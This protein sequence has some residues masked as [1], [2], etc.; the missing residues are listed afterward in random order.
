MSSTVTEKVTLKNYFEGLS[1]I[2]LDY[3]YDNKD[4]I[5]ISDNKDKNIKKLIDNTKKGFILYILSAKKKQLQLIDK[6]V[7]NKDYE[8]TDES[9]ID[10]MFFIRN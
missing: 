1:N 2:K 4:V 5:I 7:A 10:K 6:I 3:L 9:L 8:I